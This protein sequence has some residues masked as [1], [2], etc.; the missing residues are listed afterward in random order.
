M[1]PIDWVELK[2]SAIK[3]SALEKDATLKVSSEEVTAVILNKKQVVINSFDIST[4]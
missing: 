4:Q 2:C 1:I 3:R